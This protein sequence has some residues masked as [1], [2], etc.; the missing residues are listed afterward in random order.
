[1]LPLTASTSTDTGDL[2]LGLIITLGKQRQRWPLELLQPRTS[3][4]GSG[5][6]PSVPP[7]RAGRFGVAPGPEQGS[8]PVPALCPPRHR[9]TR[10]GAEPQAPGLG[11]TPRG[12]SPSSPFVLS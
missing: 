12:L 11:R 3:R 5:T 9:D 2:D 8:C 10:T 4:R 1:V 6:F 7:C